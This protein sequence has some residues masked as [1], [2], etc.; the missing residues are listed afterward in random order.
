MLE[1]TA[2]AVANTGGLEDAFCTTL[3]ILIN[4]PPSFKI[5]LGRTLYIYIYIYIGDVYPTQKV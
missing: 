3:I 5:F 1:S 4:G 2:S